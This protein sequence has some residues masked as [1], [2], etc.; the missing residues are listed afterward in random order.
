MMP[1]RPFVAPFTFILLRRW[2]RGGREQLEERVPKFSLR[3]IKDFVINIV[4]D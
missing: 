1:E 4:V 2:A 3:V